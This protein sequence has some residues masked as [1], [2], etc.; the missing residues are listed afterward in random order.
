M[1]LLAGG[2]CLGATT[3]LSSGYGFTALWLS[4]TGRGVGLAVVPATSLVTGSLL[5]GT[6]GRGT[7]LLDTVQQLGG[8]LGVAGLGSLLGF[9]YRAG[10]RTDGLPARAADAARDSPPVRHWVEGGGTE[11]LAELYERHLPRLSHGLRFYPASA[12][13]HADFSLPTVHR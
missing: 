3:E 8:V 7:S 12:S 10:L 1:A 11:D 5:E 6:T 4:L 2:V 13:P 9:G